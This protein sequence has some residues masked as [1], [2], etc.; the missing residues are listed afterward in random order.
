[1][2]HMKPCQFLVDTKNHNVNILG[3]TNNWQKYITYM[4]IRMLSGERSVLLVVLPLQ[5]TVVHLMPHKMDL[6][7]APQAQ[8]RVQ[9]CSTVVTNIW[10]Q[11]EG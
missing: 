7:R 2:G 10:F 9:R 3:Y 11:R 1:M 8:Q 5:L 6:W 4:Y